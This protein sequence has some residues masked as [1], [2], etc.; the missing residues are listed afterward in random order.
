MLN[1]N[2]VPNSNTKDD[3]ILISTVPTETDINNL[4][5]SSLSYMDEVTFPPLSPPSVSIQ[6]AEKQP[7]IENL[8]DEEGQSLIRPQKSENFI[9]KYGPTAVKTTLGTIGL[10]VIILYLGPATTCVKRESC[11][12]WLANLLHSEEAAIAVYTAGGADYAIINAYMSAKSIETFIECLKNQTSILGKLGA[13]TLIISLAASHVLQSF[14]ISSTTATQ[15]WQP[16]L[17]SGGAIPGA[18]F[19]ATGVMN[20]QIPYLMNIVRSGLTSCYREI[21]DIFSPVSELEHFQRKQEK[22]LVKEMLKF[23]EK[24]SAKTDDIIRHSKN[25]NF[26]TN[27]DFYE[28]VFRNSEAEPEFS[29][30]HA[31]SHKVGLLLGMG[32]SGLFTSPIVFDT[33]LSTNNYFEQLSARVLATFFINLPGLYGNFKITTEFMSS[34]MDSI[35]DILQGKPLNSVAFQRHQK[36]TMGAVAVATA[37]SALSYAFINTLFE[38][39]FKDQ[40]S[41]IREYAR[42]GADVAINLYH[43]HGLYCAFRLALKNLPFDAKTQYLLE[44]YHFAHAHP[45]LTKFIEFVNSRKDN[46]E[47]INNLELKNAVNILNAKGLHDLDNCEK[48]QESP[49]LPST[50]LPLPLVPNNSE[51][52]K[53]SSCLDLRAWCSWFSRPK[54]N[55]VSVSHLE[56]SLIPAPGK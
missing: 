9:K 19:G 1:R 43:F 35:V 5:T 56:E 42:Y 47:L 32:L 11:G 31:I 27:M 23:H 2:D 8:I 25:L 38:E 39:M 7:L 17:T 18:L 53:F 29:W 34:V 24:F 46:Q 6:E 52:Q 20:E 41:Q 22:M 36:M 44:L 21:V 16:Y 30:A 54:S 14:V 49:H 50:E 55:S 3:D 48:T 37:C 26:D 4:G 40:N 15:K 45:S 12:K 33:F 10:G 28:F 51:N 13:S